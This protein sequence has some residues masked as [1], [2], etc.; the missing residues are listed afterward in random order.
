LSTL[1]IAVFAYCF[2]Q[3][4]ISN[5]IVVAFLTSTAE[6]K[7]TYEDNSCLGA[8]MR[9]WNDLK[10]PVLRVVRKNPDSTSKDV[11]MTLSITEDSA[12]VALCRYY[13]Q[14]LLARKK[15]LSGFGKAHFAYTLTVR[16]L[17]RLSHLEKVVHV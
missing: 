2:G 13:R 6:T 8:E 15:R 7:N 3:D 11:A 12:Q 5:S 14:G 4:A 10:V 16:G 9:E 17:A 1:S